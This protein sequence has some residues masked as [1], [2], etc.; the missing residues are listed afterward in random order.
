MVFDTLSL[1]V[2]GGIQDE[3]LACWPFFLSI[4]ISE[5]ELVGG[6]G[7]HEGNIMVRGEPI[8]D[9]IATPENALV[10]CRYKQVYLFNRVTQN[11]MHIIFY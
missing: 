8:C 2:G 3:L 1:F 6:S 7:P 4:I 10:V 11:L 9:D 5:I